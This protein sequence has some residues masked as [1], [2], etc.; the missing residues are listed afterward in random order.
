[1]TAAIVARTLR[2]VVNR[3]KEAGGNFG[4]ILATSH[5]DLKRALDPDV[6]VDCDFGA[7]TVHRKRKRISP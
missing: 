5:N 7:R 3:S 2:L 6:L 4:A 1:V